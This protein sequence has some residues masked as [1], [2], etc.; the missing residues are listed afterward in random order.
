[1]YKINHAIVFSAMTFAIMTSSS[2]AISID[3]LNKFD[4]NKNKKIDPGS[5]QQAVI[6][7]WDRLTDHQQNLIYS[8]EEFEV[9]GPGILVTKFH[10]PTPAKECESVQ[11]FFLSDK[12]IS[13]S[14]FASGFAK[15]AGNAASFSSTENYVTGARS[16]KVDGALT[17]IFGNPCLSGDIDR[18]GTDLFFS[19]YK[20]APYVE[21]YGSGSNAATGKST[22]RTGVQSE[23]ELF[24]GPI[25]NNQLL[26][27]NPYYQTDF[28]FDADIFGVQAAWTPININWKLNGRHAT[29]DALKFW[30]NFQ[31]VLDYHK[32][33][34]AGNSGLKSG[35]HYGWIGA[36]INANFEY[37]PEKSNGI[38]G[39]AKI[40][41]FHDFVSDLSVEK[42]TTEIGIY[43]DAEKKNSFSIQYENGT[44]YQDL[45]SGKR[46]SGQFKVSF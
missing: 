37:K 14:L 4:K 9:G 39:S 7:I 25:F 38:Y 36:N 1:M 15:S 31:G 32:V 8:A 5:E 2:M 40:E 22:L 30:W 33:Q 17:W 3:E 19:A 28:E 43:L 41:V 18:G 13:T 34:N 27:I 12:A 11:R 20:L 29:T 24:S 35:T 21:F 16:W 46:L 42:L 45:T 23:F 44:N 26:K 6:N 10:E